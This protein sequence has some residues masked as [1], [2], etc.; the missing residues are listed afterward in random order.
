MTGL[1]PNLS[2]RA[3]WQPT[4]LP[5]GPVSRDIS[6]AAPSTGFEPWSRVSVR[7]HVSPP[8]GDFNIIVYCQND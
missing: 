1:T 5:G 8:G 4:V 2:T 3:L 7:R 6:V